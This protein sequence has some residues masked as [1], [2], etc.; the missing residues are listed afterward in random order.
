MDGWVWKHTSKGVYIV[1]SGYHFAMSDEPLEIDANEA[2]PW[3]LLWKIEAPEKSESFSGETAII[4]FILRN[5]LS[6]RE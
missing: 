3:K 4:F 1:K 2:E 6:Q 5:I